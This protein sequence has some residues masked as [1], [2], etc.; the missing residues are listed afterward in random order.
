MIYFSSDW[1]IGHN[2]DFLYGKR[3]FSTI[4]E[5][6]TEI[7][8]KC[9]ELVQWDDELWL[10]GDLA[11]GMNEREWNRVYESI[12]CQNVHF[13]IGNHDTNNKIDKYIEEYGFILEG[14]ANVMKVS[15]KK[16]LYLSHYP[17]VT[18]N[19]DDEI[20]SHTINLYGHTHQSTNFFYDNPYMYHVGVDSHNMYPVS[21]DQIF[22][23][24]EKEVDK[25]KKAVDFL[26]R[27]SK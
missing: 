15:K 11:L 19:F 24:I 23:D 18:D 6:D 27:V 22:K 2:K 17:T 3:G 4:E 25:H 26:K 12:N 1:H 21:L 8:K 14:Y 16:R 7:I 13:I 20:R 5:H 10:L 9:N